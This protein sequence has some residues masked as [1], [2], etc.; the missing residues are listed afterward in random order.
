MLFELLAARSASSPRR[1]QESSSTARTCAA[2]CCPLAAED[3]DRV[4]DIHERAIAY[5]EK[6]TGIDDQIEH[7]Y[8][9]LM[10]GQPE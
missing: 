2:R 8:H 6:R 9:R 3:A 10:L 7:L 5:Y 1:A 4:R